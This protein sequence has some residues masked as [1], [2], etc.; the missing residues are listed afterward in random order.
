MHRAIVLELCV[1]SIK[2]LLARGRE[3][4]KRLDRLDELQLVG[5]VLA[6]LLLQSRKPH[7][8]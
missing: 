3:G 7:L 1:A 2:P 4:L 8:D 6:N 5:V